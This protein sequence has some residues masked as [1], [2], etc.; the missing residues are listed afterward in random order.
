M[1]FQ[2][3]IKF[4]S[5]VEFWEYLP[6]DERFIVDVL[7]HIILEN[8]PKNC[9]EKLTYNVP[10]YYGNRRIC[11]LWPASVPWGGFKKGV[12]LGFNQGYKLKDPVNYLSHGTNKRVYYKIIHSLDEINEQAIIGL[13]E[14]AVEIDNKK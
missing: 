1:S 2:K 11:L 9:K 7:R 5:I 14:E 10:F 12:L 3:G 6:E 4:K 8:L 13:L